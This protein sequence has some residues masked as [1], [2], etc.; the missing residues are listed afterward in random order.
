MTAPTLI[1]TTAAATAP[2][3]AAL[4][5]RADA[6]IPVPLT[7]VLTA[8]GAAAVAVTGAWPSWW[9]PV[10]LALTVVAVPLTLADLR[11][12]RLPDVLTLPAYP[13]F[14]AAIG[15][16]ALGGGG[17]SLAVR[18][19]VGALLFG[20]AHALVHRMAPGSL[21]AGDVKLSGSLGAVLGAAGW[22]TLVLAPLLAALF[23][24]ALAMAHL[25][26]SRWARRRAPQ[27]CPGPAA[28]ALP[29]PYEPAV[30]QPASAPCE[31][32]AGRPASASCEPAVAQPASAPCEAAAGRP[33]STPR[34]P[35]VA[36]PASAP[37]EPVVG[38]SASAPCEPAV[39]QPTSPPHE[40]VPREAPATDPPPAPRRPATRPTAHPPAG[41]LGGH[42]VPHGPAL[43]AATWLCALFAAAP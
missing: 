29:A 10:P 3:A 5:K 18:A 36:Q 35:A 40:P 31:A 14:G 28:R 12:F 34:E 7:A 1:A 33:A 6:P 20:A 38:R 21:G 43:L 26:R 9:L 4:L 15:A 13:L 30:A 27:A 16:A 39:A 2:L 25:A 24:L 17:P 8:L 32:A 19:A 42:R 11:H 22:P 23:T 41:P 37:R